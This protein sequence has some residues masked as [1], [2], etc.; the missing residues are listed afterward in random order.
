MIRTGPRNEDDQEIPKKV[1]G[2]EQGIEGLR[3][4]FNHLPD[5]VKVDGFGT[6][7]AKNVFRTQH[8]TTKPDLGRWLKLS[9]R[10][11]QSTQTSRGVDQLTRARV[12]MK[13]RMK[14]DLIS[15]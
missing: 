10:S 15:S 12:T 9:Q 11:R 3:V 2:F 7:S 14:M 13:K 8:F 4:G 5:Y 6:L 1:D